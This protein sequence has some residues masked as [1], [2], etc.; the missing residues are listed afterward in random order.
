MY[1]IQFNSIQ[2]ISNAFVEQNDIEHCKI[3]MHTHY[4]RA[5]VIAATVRVVL[6]LLTILLF[7]YE[8]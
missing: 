6:L 5:I 3:V 1:K 4:M 7:K 8:V 2:F